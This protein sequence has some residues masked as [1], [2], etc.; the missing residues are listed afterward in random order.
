[1]KA[2][3]LVTTVQDDD[4]GPIRMQNIMWRMGSTPGRIRATGRAL[5]QDTDEVLTGELGIAAH[6]LNEL[7]ARGVIS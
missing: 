1:V 7:R 4:L 6:R 5:G 3:E 2:L